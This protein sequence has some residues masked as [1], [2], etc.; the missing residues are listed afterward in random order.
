MNRRRLT[1]LFLLLSLASILT[2]GALKARNDYLRRGIPESLPE[3]IA[4]SDVQLGLNVYLQEADEQ[5][6]SQTLSD[7][8]ELGITVVKQ[9]FYFEEPFDW[10]ASDRIVSAVQNQGLE[11]VPLLDGN[12]ADGYA[13]PND[14]AIFAAWTA[15]FATR[16]RK[17][18]TYYIIWDE[19][20]ITS[21]WGNQPVNAAEYAALLT[22][23]AEAVRTADADAVIVTAPLAPT[24]ETGPK[25]LADPIYLRE[26]Y[27]AGAADAFDVVAAKPYG[28]KTGPDD[29]AVEVDNLNFS[30]VILLREVM[31]AYDEGRKAIWAGNW[32]WNSLPKDWQGDGSIWGEVD[33]QMQADWT[34]EAL[35]RARQEWPWMGTMFLESWEPAARMDDPRWGF[36]IAGRPIADAIGDELANSKT[37]AFPG[38]HLAQEGGQGQAYEGGWRFSPEFGA[39]ISES[40]DSATFRFWGTDIGLRVRRAD[41]RARL[42]VTIDGEGAN[43]LPKDDRGASLVLTSPDSADDFIVTEIVARNLEPGEH[44]LTLVADR[45]WDQWALNGYSVWYQP[46]DTT[47]IVAVSALGLLAVVMLGLGIHTGRQADWRPV[48]DVLS[49]RFERFSPGWQA[50]MA[51]FIAGLVALTGWLTWG[52]QAAGVYRRLGDGGQLVVTAAAATIFYVAPSFILYL[53]AILALFILIYFRPA[54]GLALIAFAAPFYVKPKDMLGYR[55]SAVEI[56]LVVTLAAFVLTAITKYHARLRQRSK[57]VPNV[58]Y[59]LRN[60]LRGLDYAVLAFTLIGTVSLFFTER[61]DVA[62]NE[63]RV[64]MVEPAIFYFL[65]RFGGLTDKEWRTILDA[66]VMGGL[67]IA[68]IGLWQVATGQDLITAEGG[69]QRLRS[70]YGSPNNVA[71]Y[72]GRILPFLVAMF[73]LGQGKRRWFYTVALVPIGLALLLTFS[74]GALFLGI[75]ASMLVIFVIWQR[76]NGRRAWP[77][78][79]GA[80]ILGIIGLIVAFQIPQL[81]ARLNPQGETGFLR[82]NLWRASLNMFLDHPVIGVGLDN[83]LYEYRGRYILDAAWREPDLNHPHNLFLDLGTRLGLLGIFCGI[84]LFEG[85][86]RTLW[87]LAS[88]VSQ[89]LRPYAVGLIGAFVAILAHGLVDHT[90]FLIDLAYVF[91]LLIGAVVWLDT[92]DSTQRSDGL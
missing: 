42:Y 35:R 18:I 44:T 4:H 70:I 91:Y 57:V 11:L 68:L 78:V 67:V 63:W 64:V 50:F 24:V 1:L 40:G 38:F 22:A 14:P 82:L 62:T 76:G 3:P 20:N 6:L 53:V 7:I 41:F 81:A 66:F 56:F 48:G 85:I 34:V 36:S 30:R 60:H 27:E 47:Y 90:F 52:E 65:L 71:L 46:P 15:E 61:L 19:P 37:T 75:P 87:G 13:P 5:E 10:G 25:N 84:W 80:G 49:G 21:H 16:Y 83:F 51:T 17:S 26:L 55:F 89:D 92:T 69:L 33:D 31:T 45:G 79:L 8:A 29:R 86:R 2:I 73:L 28:F 58:R 39:D 43:Q 54:W 23:A 32:G 77:W 88:H 72:F 59:W 9:S 12:P 74:K